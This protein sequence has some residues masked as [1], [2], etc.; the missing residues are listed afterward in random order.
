MI[1]TWGL[2]LWVCEELILMLP[3]CLGLTSA[4]LIGTSFGQTY[5][6][7]LISTN[8]LHDE[9]LG[10][11]ALDFHTKAH[12]YTTAKFI[13]VQH[14]LSNPGIK[15]RSPPLQVDS[16][17]AEAWGKPRNT[18]AGSLS[19]LQRIFLTQESNQGLL[20]CRWVLYQ[21]SYQGSQV[22]R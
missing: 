10:S 18:G 20:H 16:L 9:Y 12:T 13:T 11:D 8:I 1:L 4:L 2:T 19:L 22:N 7:S 6:I 21:V 3:L 14:D 15:P 17:P 5:H